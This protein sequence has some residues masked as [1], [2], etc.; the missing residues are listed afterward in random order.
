MKPAL[1]LCLLALAL[2]LGAAVATD[3]VASPSSS[4]SSTAVAPTFDDD[5]DTPVSALSVGDDD[6]DVDVEDIVDL[7]RD[8]HHHAR[9]PRARAVGPPL[10]YPPPMHPMEA[11]M[12]MRPMFPM[13]LDAD[14][15]HEHHRR[16]PAWRDD[17][18]D[19]D[20]PRHEMTSLKERCEAVANAK[21][22]SA[23]EKYIDRKLIRIHYDNSEVPFG[24]RY[25]GM[26]G[27]DLFRERKHNTMK[28][29]KDQTKTRVVSLDD[30]SQVC[31]LKTN[32][33]GTFAR[34]GGKFN[35]ISMYK[36]LSWEFGKI[37][38]IELIDGGSYDAFMSAYY[39][40]A[41][42]LAHVLAET[43]HEH[44]PGEQVDALVADGCEARLGRDKKTFTGKKAVSEMLKEVAERVKKYGFA[45]EELSLPWGTMRSKH[46]Q[47]LF[48]DDHSVGGF[49]TKYNIKTGTT[50]FS[51]IKTF[52][53]LQFDLEGR[54]NRIA[55]VEG[56]P[57]APGE[58]ESKVR[59]SLE[60]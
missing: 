36:I 53:Y 11:M 27:V 52:F 40:N 2:G 32:M 31:V 35:N 48:A 60:F 21:D 50:S 8:D 30:P 43:L 10:S 13:R 59:E 4:S 25:H 14:G 7:D 46:T 18:D 28:I 49:T 12:M 17:D 6:N 47:L 22:W 9:R 20:E 55:V 51:R 16:H 23:V 58:L 5:N 41:Q 57:F 1:W 44:G 54:L 37:V 26:R 15:H 33:T 34:S 38:K 45:R 29:D 42:K 39:T 56:R 3:P 19:E 24:G